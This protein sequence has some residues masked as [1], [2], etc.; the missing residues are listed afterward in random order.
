[1]LAHNL[2]RWTARL[3]DVH[4]DDQLTVTRTVRTRLLAPPGRLVNRSRQWTL[5]LPVR[6]PCRRRSTPRS[7]G[8]AR[9]RC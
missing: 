7:T 5:R 8:S 3:G 4:P 9:C 2:I 6:W 1:V